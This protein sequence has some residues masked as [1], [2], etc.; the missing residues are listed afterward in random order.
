PPS[1]EFE[2]FSKARELTDPS[3]QSTFL[4]KACSDDME[5]R[6]RIDRLLAM[7]SDG[8]KFMSPNDRPE[9]LENFSSSYNWTPPSAKQLDELIEGCEVH[10][11]L[12]RGG[13]GAVY[14]GIQTSLNR[15]VAIKILPPTSAR[16]SKF[17]ERFRG[18]ALAMA[19]LHHPNIVTIFE[20]GSVD[21]NSG[22]VYYIVMEF[23]NGT[24]LQ[25][26]IKSGKL[27][28]GDALKLVAQVCEAIQYAHSQGLLHRDIKPAN[29]FVSTEGLVKVGDFGL[30]K[31]MSDEMAEQ[32]LHLT[33]TGYHI[34]TPHYMAPESTSGQKL[35]HRAD[36]YSLGVMLYEMLTG[37][38]PQGVFSPPSA[39]INVDSR[40]DHVVNRA[41]QADPEKRFQRTQDLKSAIDEI[42]SAQFSSAEKSVA[43]GRWRLLWL[44]IGMIGLIA[45]IGVWQFGPLLMESG[46]DELVEP[47]AVISESTSGERSVAEWVVSNELGIV[48]LEGLDAETLEE[49]PE[50]GE[51][52]I[53]GLRF[54]SPT[55]KNE[56]LHQL[57]RLRHLKHLKIGFDPPITA[58][59]LKSLDGIPLEELSIGFPIDAAIANQLAEFGDLRK[60]EIS[61]QDISPGL[62]AQL[63]SLQKLEELTLYADVFESPERCLAEIGKIPA[64]KSLVVADCN[65]PLSAFADLRPASELRTLLLYREPLTKDGVQALSHLKQLEKLLIA[66]SDDPNPFEKTIELSRR[67]PNCRILTADRTFLNGERQ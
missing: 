43:D 7:D 19:K 6:Q 3:D 2:L 60:L 67:L 11:M 33:Q 10:E 21:S 20:Y 30:A 66:G 26:L 25:R 17:A 54:E 57:Q 51:I 42:S 55:L 39:M 46:E 53:L 47:G 28:V 4:D 34:G 27:V 56:D 40:L 58:S 36:I 5:L 15:P 63:R 12:G 24:D 37:A 48:V 45:S 35:D 22:T 59:G 16:D 41:I 64:L 50:E 32:Q 44:G 29:I 9:V 62:F 49:L 61:G 1:D 38:L 31:M 23:V 14:R 13:M 65:A 52:Q 8:D 18:E